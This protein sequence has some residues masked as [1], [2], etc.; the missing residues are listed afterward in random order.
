MFRIGHLDDSNDLTPMAA[1]SGCEMGLKLAG[2][3]PASLGA[4]AAMEY[5]AAHPVRPMLRAAA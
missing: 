2:V 3:K 5:F 4:Q 1:R